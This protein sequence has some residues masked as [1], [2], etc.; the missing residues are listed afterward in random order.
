MRKVFLSI[1]DFLTKDQK[2]YIRTMTCMILDDNPLARDISSQ[3]VAQEE[4]LI[5]AAECSSAQEAIDY[6]KTNTVDLILMDIEMPQI[7]GL[8]FLRSLTNRPLIIIV[9]GHAQ[10]A[11]YG[12]EF[13]V[14]DYLVKP[15]HPDRFRVAI[16]KAR[17]LLAAK[18]RA[19]GVQN[20][21]FIF[22]KDNSVLQKINFSDM[23]WL[24]AQGDY[25]KV[26]TP[27]KSFMVHTTLKSIED[28]L[29]PQRFVRVHRSFVIS[30]EKIDK[31]EENIIYVKNKAIPV[32]DTYWKSLKKRLDIV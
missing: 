20:K 18:S 16:E 12:Y 31:I 10:Y 27:E 13:S 19:W 4:D 15:V 7:S 9:S 24:E 29:P 2:P 28:K 1:L 26:H 6:L 23:L 21:E 14:A 30:L 32:S 5:L 17:N 25:V 11:V 3:L 8:E 22:I